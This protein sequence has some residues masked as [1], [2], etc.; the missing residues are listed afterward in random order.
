MTKADRDYR[1][2]LAK[3][4]VIAVPT[5]IEAPRAIDERLFPFQ[6]DIVRWALRRGRAAIFA[7]TGLGKTAMQL[8]WARHI[9]EHT[10]GDVLI[11]TPL[12]VAAQTVREGQKFGIEVTHC[13]LAGDIRPGINVINYDRMHLV[14]PS[15]FAGVVI[16]ES[17]C[18]KDYTSAT[19]NEL[20][21]AFCKTPFRL[22]CTATPA[23]N[24]FTELGNHSEFLGIMRR[25]E[26]LS[27]WFV[28][29]GGSTKDWRVKGH[30]E[31]D[32]WQWVCSWAAVIRKPSDLEYEDG[33]F[34]LPP[35]EMLPHVI[36]SDIGVA[37]A[38]GKLFVE[39]AQ[40]LEDQRAAR[41]VSLP[42]RV[43]ECAKIVNAAVGPFLVWCELNTESS[44]LARA[45]P[46]AVEVSGADSSEEKERKMIDFSEGR[47]R[48]MISKPKIAGK[49]LNWQHCSNIAFVGV[50]HSFEQFYQAV[51]RCWRFGQTRPVRC[52][53][54]TSEIEGAVTANLRRK[55][56][57]AKKMSEEMSA[58]TA[59]IVRGTIHEA[60]REQTL[61]QTKRE[62]T[63]P[64]WVESETMI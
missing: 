55:E 26:M 46:D 21:G 42:G 40:T 52:H 9:R 11:L 41:R 3:K 39:Q 16:D 25:V 34:E 32:F 12:A 29:D 33:A 10:G 54:I 31:K 47:V 24:D 44:E 6:R 58:K 62:M 50:S 20:I 49:G 51:R 1:A 38:M 43:A 30:A 5:G 23:P 48:V 22:A 17:S 18:L 14:D 27:M 35:L 57:A 45:I 2:F 13:K 56:A 7:D 37:H 53:I 28:H 60:R 8:E 63:V 15:S 61:Y 59:S 19:R 4:A 64:S 36:P